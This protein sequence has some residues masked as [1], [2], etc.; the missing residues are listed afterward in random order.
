M[1]KNQSLYDG[2]QL[3][4]SLAQIHVPRMWVERHPDTH[5]EV[6]LCT[7]LCCPINVVAWWLP[8][9]GFGSALHLVSLSHWILSPFLRCLTELLF[10]LFSEGHWA[11]KASLLA[12]SSWHITTCQTK[13]PLSRGS[14]DRS[15]GGSRIVLGWSCDCAK[16]RLGFS[17]AFLCIC[18][19][20]H[21]L[22][23]IIVLESM[24]RV[25]KYGSVSSV[26]LKIF[27]LKSLQIGT[28]VLHCVLFCA[29]F[30]SSPEVK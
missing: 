18:C 29:V 20:V 24:N 10:D 1:A 19:P 15:M 28:K 3:W 7:Y 12:T 16:T 9:S 21:S 23:F 8:S 2:F 26:V 6:Y 14:G 30:V 13:T 5:H 25:P 4:I 22:Q 17:A 27:S 11:I